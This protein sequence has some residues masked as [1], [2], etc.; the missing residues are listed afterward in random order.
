M[1]PQLPVDPAHTAEDVRGDLPAIRMEILVDA[2]HTAWG[3]IANAYE[4]NWDEA[5]EEWRAAAIRWR[6]E[7]FH[8]LLTAH[9]DGL[10]APEKLEP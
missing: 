3:I 2:L 7:E 10:V 4:G 5:P 9:L 8:P 1:N 6:D